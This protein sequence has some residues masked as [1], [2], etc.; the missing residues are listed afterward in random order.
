MI[1]R[2]TATHEVSTTYRGHDHLIRCMA[3]PSGASNDEA[4]DIASG[5]PIHG[6]GGLVAWLDLGCAG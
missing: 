3:A 5:R 6:R 1:L 2:Q 4:G